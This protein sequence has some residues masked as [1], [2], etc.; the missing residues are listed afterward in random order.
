MD[1]AVS[2][3]LTDLKARNLLDDTIVWMTGEFGRTTKIDMDPTWQ[4]G[5]HHFPR[6]FSAL[7]AGGGFKGGV[8]VGKSDDTAA[9]VKDRPVT[10]AD[11]LGSICELAGIN[12]D[13]HLPNGKGFELPVLPPASEIGRLKEIYA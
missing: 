13:D 1:T 6:C 3:L 11:F 2:A 10:P 5:R 7:V 4:G 8:A 12:P 9:N